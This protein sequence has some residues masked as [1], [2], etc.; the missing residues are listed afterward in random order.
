MRSFRSAILAIILSG[1]VAPLA[2]SCDLC[3]IYN[4]L[5]SQKGTAGALQL[6]VA[7]QFTSYSR[8]QNNGTFVDNDEHQ[9]LS[10]SITQLFAGYNISNSVSAQISLP[11]INRR[12]ARVEGESID[13]GTEAGIGDLPIIV[14]YTP[15]NYRE[16]DSAF[17]IQLLAGIKLPTGS[18]DRLKEEQQENHHG[19]VDVQT[20]DGHMEVEAIPRHEDHDHEA[21]S[22]IHGHD[23]ALGSGSVDFPVG[24]R[25]F[26][27]S[28][29]LF[30]AADFQYTIRN[31]GDYDYRYAND[32]LWNVGPAYY[33]VLHHDTTVAL[34]A[35][36]NGEYKGKD[37]GNGEQQN[38]TSINTM[39]LGPQ[40][41]IAA[42]GCLHGEFGVDFPV[43]QENSGLQAV[44]S[45]RF[46]AG[47]TYR[48]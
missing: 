4:S 6:G 20:D 21:S 9:R 10:S 19:Q 46:R 48:F 33:I 8:I 38:G 3:S 41:L 27:E 1:A 17:T 7:E 30:G 22:V 26:A 24:A 40:V 14:R 18:S 23:L 43:H 39:F 47:L 12:F 42:G 45:Y 44:A 16:S 34:R 29:R 32:L 15:Y 37:F 25:F 11:Y 31:K 2:Y 35:N 36:L 5:E 13:R 28:G